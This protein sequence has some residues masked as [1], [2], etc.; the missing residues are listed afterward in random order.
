MGYCCI[1]QTGFF[2]LTLITMKNTGHHVIKIVAFYL[3]AYASSNS[4]MFTL[5]ILHN[6]QV[7]DTMQHYKGLAK[8]T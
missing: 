3:I 7:I 2:T 4:A 1:G 6:N 5:L 8:K